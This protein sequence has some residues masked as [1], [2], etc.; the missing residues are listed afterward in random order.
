M[1]KEVYQYFE[2]MNWKLY[3]KSYKPY[4]SK[5][6]NLRVIKKNNPGRLFKRKTKEKE[7]GK[8]GCDY[9]IKIQGLANSS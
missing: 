3:T 4:Y 8:E 7:L 6:K 1:K 9:L 5:L 2:E